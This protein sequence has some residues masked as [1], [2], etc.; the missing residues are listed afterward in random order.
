[1]TDTPEDEVTYLMV[2]GR[3]QNVMFRQTIMRAAI[4]R[5]ITAGAT[6][7]KNDRHRVD[8]SLQGPKDKIQEIIDGLKSGKP[9]NSWGANCTTV[10]IVDTGKKPLEHE[11]NTSNVDNIRWKKGVKFYL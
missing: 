8:I 7:N 5:N 6:N 9:L 10:E 11:V 4:S 3:V 2:K 1:M